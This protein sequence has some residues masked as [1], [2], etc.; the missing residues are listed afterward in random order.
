DQLAGQD[1]LQ[2][3]LP[4]PVGSMDQQSRREQR[5]AQGADDRRRPR[6]RQLFL[7]DGL[8]YRGGRPPAGG[9]RPAELQPA[10][11][12]QTP[13]PVAADV[14]VLVIAITA[15]A[16]VPPLRRQVLLQPRAHLVAERLVLAPELQIHDSEP[17]TSGRL[18]SVMQT[19]VLC[20][21][22][23][24]ALPRPDAA[25]PRCGAAP[26]GGDARPRSAGV[27]RPKNPWLAAALAA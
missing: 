9:L 8:H 26:S 17:I 4:L 24:A 22:C 16:A 7:V 13:L 10:A 20:G 21:R 23:G 18:G 14:I 5:D 11:F 2:V 25:C 27:P 12:V 3:L 19:Q 6:V 1:L 15:D